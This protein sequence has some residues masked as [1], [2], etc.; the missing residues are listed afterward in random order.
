M[1][2]S[3]KSTIY[4]YAK[5]NN[6]AENTKIVY[7]VSMM[8]WIKKFLTEK[9]DDTE[10]LIEDVDTQFIYQFE[11][12]LNASGKL[13]PSS[14]LE[15]SSK[16]RAVL[17]WAS[18]LQLISPDVINKYQSGLIKSRRETNYEHTMTVTDL[19]RI[20]RDPK[21]AAD[22]PIRRKNMPYKRLLFLLQSWT[23]F[24]YE[25]LV[26]LNVRKAIRV[27]AAGN[28]SIVYNRAKGGIPATL[29][30]FPEAEAILET[31]DYKIKPDE[32]YQQFL[33]AT[34]KLF[35]LYGLN[36]STLGTHTGRHVFGERMIFMGFPL[37]DVSRMMG[38]S[39]VQHT[40]KVYAKI[41]INT[42]QATYDRLKAMKSV[43]KPAENESN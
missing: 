36:S 35:K 16:L 22:F 26:Q 30:L 42:I 17:D 19:D 39:T 7:T 8:K 14:A 13:K 38:H 18:R 2:Q 9:Y 33:Y 27:D 31:L 34:K 20:E 28:K 25:D 24:S 3:L 5:S 37:G 29:P 12:F 6:L 15:Y 11:V 10:Y 4:D 41:N 40:E 21:P 43:T 1:S 32:K 23:G